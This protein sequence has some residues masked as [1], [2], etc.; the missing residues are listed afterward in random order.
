MAVDSS[1]PCKAAALHAD[2][3]EPFAGALSY[4]GEVATLH[5][6]TFL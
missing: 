6:S 4:G 2:G 1:M 5:S 3:R